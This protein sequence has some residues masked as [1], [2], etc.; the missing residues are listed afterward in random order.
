MIAG[1]GKNDYQR[2]CND[3]FVIDNQDLLSRRKYLLG[4]I[5]MHPQITSLSALPPRAGAGE[6]RIPSSSATPIAPLTFIFFG[7]PQRR[8]EAVNR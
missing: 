5:E 2:I 6:M 3:R 1:F 7:Y 8:L 4:A